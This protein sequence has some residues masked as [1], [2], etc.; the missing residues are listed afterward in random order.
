MSPDPPDTVETER[1]TYG[2]LFW[3]GLVV[4]WSVIGFAI[5]GISNSVWLKDRPAK[6]AVWVLGGLVVHDAIVASTVTAVG[7]VL[8]RLLPRSARGP[9]T[10]AV[11]LSGLV[12]PFS[13][14]LWRGF[15]R[16]QSNTSILPL[17]Y[18]RNVAI[19]VALIWLTTTTIVVGRLV[20]GDRARS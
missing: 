1:P 10:G 11:A 17:D 13:Y 3:T 12:V 20:R 14:P 16:R 2:P 4:G 19:V 15:G 8:T 9:I 7:L 5:V 6:L 18:G